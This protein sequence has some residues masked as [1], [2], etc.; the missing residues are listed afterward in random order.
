MRVESRGTR[1][2]S[3]REVGIRR[4]NKSPTTPNMPAVHAKI[5]PWALDPCVSSPTTLRVWLGTRKT[6]RQE[7]YPLFSI[8]YPLGLSQLNTRN[9][10]GSDSGQRLAVHGPNLFVS[11]ALI[12]ITLVLRSDKPFE[13][14]LQLFSW[15]VG[16]PSANRT[17][18]KTPVAFRPYCRNESLNRGLMHL[19]EITLTLQPAFALV[20]HHLQNSVQIECN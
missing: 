17:G 8:C 19:K 5:I 1:G 20:L 2:A 15:I 10:S 3:Q 4:M 6:G 14:Q 11:T 16:Y 12:S 13:Y 7:N 18:L 9:S